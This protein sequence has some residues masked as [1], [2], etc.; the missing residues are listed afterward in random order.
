MASCEPQI[1]SHDVGAL[2][3]LNA[4]TEEATE[5]VVGGNCCGRWHH[6]KPEDTSTGLRS[7]QEAKGAR[8]ARYPSLSTCPSGGGLG[9]SR[10]LLVLAAVALLRAANDNYPRGCS[11]KLP[12]CSRPAPVEELVL[13]ACWCATAGMHGDFLPCGVQLV[14]LQLVE[15]IAREQYPDAMSAQNYVVQHR[16]G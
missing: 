16:L 15:Q 5:E 10:R 11:L 3:V 4:D 7:A 9:G 1:A 14:S 2:W 13:R 6:H 12:D 8:S